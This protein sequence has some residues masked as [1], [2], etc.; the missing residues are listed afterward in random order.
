MAIRDTLKVLVATGI[1][2]GLATPTVVRAHDVLHR[3]TVLEVQAERLQVAT[4]GEESSAGEN[5]WFAVTADTKVKRGD[6][7]VAYA[8]AQIAKGERIVVVVYHTGETKNIATELRLA[9]R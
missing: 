9:A 6:T 3:G 7:L 5:V 8:D 4:I 2:F 1:A